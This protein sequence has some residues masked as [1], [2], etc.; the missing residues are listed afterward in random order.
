MG[1][2][3]FGFEGI[4]H[5]GILNLRNVTDRNEIAVHLL[6][7]IKYHMTKETEIDLNKLFECL[8][9]E[10]LGI[11]GTH[12]ESRS[13]QHAINSFLGP[14]GDSYASYKIGDKLIKMMY[15]I[16]IYGPRRGLSFAHSNYQDGVQPNGN[17]FIRWGGTGGLYLNFSNNQDFMRNWILGK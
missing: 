3:F 1:G 15:Q 14:R 2:G 7:G 5:P 13:N 16:P 6:K 17:W 12:L 9:T 11:G 10:C 8:S 4:N